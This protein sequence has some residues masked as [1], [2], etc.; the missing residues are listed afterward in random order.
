MVRPNHYLTNVSV[1]HFLGLDGYFGDKVFPIVPVA[2]Q[3]SFYYEFNKGDIAR[4]DMSRK[5]EFGSV[6]PSVIG[7]DDKIYNCKVDQILLGIDEISQTNY[8][9]NGTLPNGVLKNLKERRSKLIAE[10]IKL[11]IDALFAENFFNKDAW[12]QVYTGSDSTPGTNGFFHF[13]NANSDIVNL[14]DSLCTE[15]GRNGRRRPNKITLGVDAYDAIKNNP[16]IL[17]RIKYSG[18]TANPAIVNTNVLA[19]LFGVEEVLVADS[20]RN[21]ADVGQ[22]AKMEYIADRKGMLLSYAPKSAAIDEPSA[23]YIFAWDMGLGNSLYSIKD[24]PSKDATHTSI[25]EGL[26]ALDM[27]KTGDDLGIYLS[28]CVK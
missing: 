2:L 15:M 16:L 3:S 27:K 23:G 24:Y 21:I 7:S 20:T 4:D 17:E 6:Q 1:V 9:R 26:A 8:S 25:V 13:D 10:K 11:H 18:S 14:I 28:N 12:T 19:Q 22:E 5:P